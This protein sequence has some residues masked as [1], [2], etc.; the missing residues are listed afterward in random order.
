[1]AVED[2]GRK[3]MNGEMDWC[4]ESYDNVGNDL[5]TNDCHAMSALIGVLKRVS[6]ATS[7]R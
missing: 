3:G 2:S 6:G 1:M 4:H 5:T 7:L